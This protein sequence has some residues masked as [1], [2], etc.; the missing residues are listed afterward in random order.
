[1]TGQLQ[2]FG[3]LAEAFPQVTGHQP[4][5][6]EGTV[7]RVIEIEPYPSS[8]TPLGGCTRFTG[9]YVTD[10]D[11]IAAIARRVRRGKPW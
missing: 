6:V 9:R 8:P 5:V 11:E 4:L 10:P 2:T 7:T 1:M 3:Q